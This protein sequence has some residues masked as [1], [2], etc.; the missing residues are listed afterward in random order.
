MVEPKEISKTSQGLSVVCQSDIVFSHPGD[1]VVLSCHL[2]PAISAASMEIQW[3]HKEDPVFHYKNGQMTVNIDFEGRVSLP[4]Q[5]LQNGNV[6][7][8][9]RDIRGSQ[10]GLYICEITHES[11][12]IQ[13]T[14]FLHISSEDFRLV[15]PVGT[16]SADPGSDVILPVHLSPETSAVPLDIRWFRGTELIY[17]YKNRK[18]K[19]N[20]ENRVS[21][22]T[23]ELERGNLAL[24]L[25][26]FQPA[27]SGDYTCKVFHD[28]CL[29]TG[30]VHLQV[31]E[32]QRCDDARLRHLHSVLQ[33]V[34]ND[35]LLQKAQLL[36]GTIN[37]LQETLN[38]D[39]MRNNAF[40]PAPRRSNSREGIPPLMGDDGMHQ[41]RT[42]EA[43]SVVFERNFNMHITSRTHSSAPN[44]ARHDG[45]QNRRR[46]SE[47]NI[48]TQQELSR[49]IIQTQNLLRNIRDE[50]TIVPTSSRT[51]AQENPGT[52]IQSIATEQKTSSSAVQSQVQER[53]RPSESV[54]TLAGE[55]TRT[56]ERPEDGRQRTQQRNE[57]IKKTCQIM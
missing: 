9:L 3:W 55:S 10:K 18:E 50:S 32:I 24:T 23:Q 12:S 22:F 28:G 26:N 43:G 20:F 21:L 42:M 44:M 15:T 45:G 29:Q 13:D 51:H 31:R 17:Q 49:L 57:N 47:G 54:M 6:S 37:L 36:Q 7:L 2:K 1:D 11:Q 4:L 19:T 25:R 27:D 8:T 40:G 33:Q 39:E 53:E 38:E 56:S 48:T 52:S 30:T 46:T 16:V 5:D 35:I 34:Q 41:T 14:V